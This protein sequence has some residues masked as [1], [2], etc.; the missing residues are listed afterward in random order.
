MVLSNSEREP[1]ARLRRENRRPQMERDML[2]KGDEDQ[3]TVQ[4]TVCPRNAWF[5]AK[6]D[7]KFTPSTSS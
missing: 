7:E 3:R 4:W 5:A 1:L 6:S 2:A